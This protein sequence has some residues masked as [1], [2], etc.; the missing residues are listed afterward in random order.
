MSDDQPLIVARMRELVD[1]HNYPLVVTT[2]GTGPA[3]RDVTPEA[4][5]EVVDRVLPGFG[6]RMRAISLDYVP[7]AILSRQTAGLYKSSVIVNLP[8]WSYDGDGNA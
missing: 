1:V 8:V 6:E 2:G 5:L 7:T 3:A 4:T